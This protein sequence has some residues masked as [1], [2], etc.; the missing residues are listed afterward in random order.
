MKAALALTVLVGLVCCAHAANWAL[1]IAGSNTWDNYRHQADVLHAYNVLNVR[2]GIP[3]SNIV[4]MTYDGAL[5]E[6]VC[7]CW[8]P[9]P[10]AG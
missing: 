7:L 6:P 8:L 1:V 10:C 3:Q 4:S 5:R 9:S 2:G